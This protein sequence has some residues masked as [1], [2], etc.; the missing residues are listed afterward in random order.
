MASIN[1]ISLKAA[2]CFK[3]MER[4]DWQGNIYVGTKKVAFW[5]QSR[6]DLDRIDMVDGYSREK[7]FEAMK[8]YVDK[9]SVEL[10][11]ILESFMDKLLCLKDDEAEFKKMMKKEYKAML[12]LSD[13]YHVKYYCYPEVPKESAEELYAQA[14]YESKNLFFKDAKITHRFYKGL[15]DFVIGGKLSPDD[16]KND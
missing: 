10:N 11:I 2:K 5:S 3:S 14:S 9:K 6:S 7:L 15:E 4:P 8:P 13:G 16:I 1:G 12:V